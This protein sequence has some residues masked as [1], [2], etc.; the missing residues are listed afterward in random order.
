MV[1]AACGPLLP[2]AMRADEALGC[3]LASAVVAGEDVPP[4]DN[5]AMDG[6]AVRA[7]DTASAP[8]VLEVLGTLAAGGRAEAVVGP[9]Q[10]LKIMTG[11]PMPAG[12]DAIVKVEETVGGA[13]TVTVN[14]P[15]RR[16]DHVRPA[17][18][19]LVAGCEV[20]TAGTVLGPAHAGVLASIGVSEVLALP[21]ARVGVISCGDELVEGPVPLGQ[22]KI[23]DSNRPAL[24][25]LVRQSGFEAVD[26]G[27]LRDDEAAIADALDAATKRCDA[28]L[29]SGGVSAGDFDYVKVAIERLS[30]EP[31]ASMQVAIK[32]AKPLAFATIGG[33]P[34]FG[35]PGNPVS[36]MVSFE[37]FARPALRSMM[38]FA[39][40]D[41]PTVL[42]ILDEPVGRSR[43]GKLHLVRAVSAP[44]EDGRFHVRPSGGQGSHMLASMARANCLALVE[45]GDGAEAGA[46]VPVMLLW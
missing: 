14:R 10:A 13:G 8:V 6:Y 33:T 20:F 18:D 15:A 34:V 40:L 41:R 39:E 31:M 17:G 2:R 38:G 27:I 24:L 29:T 42:A 35:L 16:G 25:A 23:R 28:V 36:S 19:D 12:A 44:A 45:D 32:P 22:G 37:L 9:G 21:R 5:T 4:F 7:A 46:E 30:G 1:L 11:A 3:V 26:L 43:D